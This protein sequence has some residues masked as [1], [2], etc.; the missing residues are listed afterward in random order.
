MTSFSLVKLLLVSVPQHAVHYAAA[1]PHIEQSLPVLV[2]HLLQ[3]QPR[4][5]TAESL[6]NKEK[7][8]VGRGKKTHSNLVELAKVQCAV[9]VDGR[10]DVLA[11]IAVFDQLQLPHTADVSEP[12]LDLRHV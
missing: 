5:S 8:S 12:G 6:K 7:Q 2:S 9:A 1:V 4:Q 10:P 3:R 11:V